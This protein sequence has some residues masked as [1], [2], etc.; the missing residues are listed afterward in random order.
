MRYEPNLAFEGLR[1]VGV[2]VPFGDV[3]V[4]GGFLVLV[5]QTKDTAVALLNLGRLP[6][7]VEVM[8]RNEALLDVG[9]GAHLLRAADQRADGDCRTFSKRAYLLASDSA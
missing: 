6:W 3:V 2:E 5:A 7:G 9:A 4:D 8:Q 1:H